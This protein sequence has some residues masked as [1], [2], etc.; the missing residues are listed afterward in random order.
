MARPDPY[1]Y[2]EQ[3][4]HYDPLDPDYLQELVEQVFG[5]AIAHYFRPRLVGAES[6]PTRGPAILACNHS[7]N[8]FP[9]DGMVLDALLWRRE[10]FPRR[11]KIRT[12]FERELTTTWWMRPFGI[13][14]FW[15][16]GGGVDMTFDNFDRLLQGGERVLY[17]PEGVP[18]IGK[19]FFRR[20]RL[21]RFSSSF[22][23]LGARHRAPIHPVYIVNA[24][25]TIPLCFTVPWIDRLAERLVGVPFIPLPAAPLG[26]LFP[27]LWYLAL[28]VRMVFVAGEPLDVAAM[29]EEEQ[30]QRPGLPERQVVRAVAERVRGHMQEGLERAAARYGT[31]PFHARSLRLHLKRHRR[32]LLGILPTGWA[33]RFVR[34]ER[35]RRRPPARNRLHS[36]VRDWDLFFFYVPLGWPVL[37]LAR[38]FR[39]PPCGFR[40]LTPKERR[41]REGG[42]HWHLKE[43]PLPPPAAASRE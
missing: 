25:W 1:L 42:F 12:V 43:R 40:S 29:V 5:P 15:R 30:R 4:P 22:V 9:Y 6:L 38:R 36:L 3:F 34:H 16:R 7:G 26:V 24:E 33:W 21:Q 13:D 35:E 11:G 14:N 19:G 27:F 32:E 37:S 18:G 8:S 17:F 10:G 20:Y 39:K 28:P 41:E 31:R 2:A 23:T